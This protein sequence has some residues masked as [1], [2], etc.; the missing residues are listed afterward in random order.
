MGMKK[1]F[2][3]FSLLLFFA[4]FCATLLVQKVHSNI[5]PSTSLKNHFLQKSDNNG[6]VEI[7]SLSDSQ[8]NSDSNDFEKVKFDYSILEQEWLMHFFG[9]SFVHIPLAAI[10]NHIYISAPRYILYH[11]LQIAGC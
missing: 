9:Q 2:Y 8:D 10:Q 7:Y 4:T 1:R 5:Y 3:I 6:Q 11:S